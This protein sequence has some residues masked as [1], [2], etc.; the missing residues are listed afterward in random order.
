[1]DILTNHFLLSIASGTFNYL[2]DSVY[3]CLY[4]SGASFS[5]DSVDYTA[6]NELSSGNGYNRLDKLVTDKTISISDNKVIYDCSDITWTASGGVIGPARYM[7]LVSDNKYLYIMDFLE[8]KT[9]GDGTL[10]RI[11]IDTSGLFKSYRA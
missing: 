5:V 3:A 9:A 4:G 2:D 7:A 6:T 10:F 8:D 11:T 1:M